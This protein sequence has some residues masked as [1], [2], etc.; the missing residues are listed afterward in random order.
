MVLKVQMD[1]YF[2]HPLYHRYHRFLLPDHWVQKVLLHLF[3]PYHQYP[4]SHLLVLKDRW[5]L[6]DQMALKILL[7]RFPLYH[8][9]HRL[10]PLDH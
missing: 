1:R 10:N 3:H 2:Q 5:D 4:L 7:L 9:F 6:S 8:L